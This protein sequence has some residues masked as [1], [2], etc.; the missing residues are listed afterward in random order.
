MKQRM[1]IFTIV[2]LSIALTGLMII[3]GYWIYS[4]YKVKQANFVRTVNEAALKVIVTMEKL[5]MVH[6]L[7]EPELSVKNV[8]SA[9][10]AV[11]SINLVLLREMQSINTRKDLEIFYNKYFIKRELMEDRMFNMDERTTRKKIDIR[12]LD[13]LLT[14]EFSQRNMNTDWEFGVYNPFGNELRMKE[15]SYQ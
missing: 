11:D 12:T 1:I 5:E 8:K 14:D 3:Q 4:A 9:V 15:G 6:R 7:Q 13:S 2:M 10:E